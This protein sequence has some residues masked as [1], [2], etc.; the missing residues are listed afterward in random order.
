MKNV[1]LLVIKITMLLILISY[2]ALPSSCGDSDQ[3]E[4]IEP[5]PLNLANELEQLK[6]SQAHYKNESE[7][8]KNVYENESFN[9]SNQNIMYIKNEVYNINQQIVNIDQTIMNIENK[10]K[11]IYFAVFVTLAESLFS[12]GIV[13]K[14]YINK[15][16]E[17]EAN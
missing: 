14:N 1:G 11:I 6:V 13:I 4:I 17:N 9:V 10:V 12:I 3:S 7:Y 2:L 16:N 8:W 5:E 15:K